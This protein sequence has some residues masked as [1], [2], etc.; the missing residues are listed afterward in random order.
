MRKMWWAA[1]VLAV[2]AAG[3][4]RAADVEWKPIDTKKLMVQPSRTAAAL[5][6]ATI[7]MAGKT[8]AQSVEG[9]GYVKT[10]NNLFGFRRS[11]PTPTQAGPSALPVPGIF[12]ST[13]YASPL[14]P[15]MPT[16]MPSRR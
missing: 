8:A 5:T 1:A 10:L 3:P 6:A 11:I 2:A 12:K 15:Q 13:Q 14:Q 4:A 9:N 16:S 7:D